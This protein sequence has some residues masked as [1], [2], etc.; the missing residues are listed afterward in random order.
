MMNPLTALYTSVSAVCVTG[1]T[2]IDPGS[3]LTFWGQ[4]IL[5]LLIQIVGLGFMT[6]I[7]VFF[8]GFKT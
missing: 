5:I 2:L 3:E 1:L 8:S 7:T 6:V 4:L